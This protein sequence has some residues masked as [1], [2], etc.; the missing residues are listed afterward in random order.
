MTVVFAHPGGPGPQRFSN[1]AP[2]ESL[3]F[4]FYYQV[5]GADVVEMVDPTATVS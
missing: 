1:F 3:L 4:T 5:G 2:A